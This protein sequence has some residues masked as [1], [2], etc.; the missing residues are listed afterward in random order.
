M[1]RWYFLLLLVI[2][3]AIAAFVVRTRVVPTLECGR[4]PPNIPN[5]LLKTVGQDVYETTLSGRVLIANLNQPVAGAAVRLRI[6]EDDVLACPNYKVVR[7]FNLVS[8]AQGN[9]RLPEPILVGLRPELEY[10][11]GVH[12]E[13][14]IVAVESPDCEIIPAQ[15]RTYA[16]ADFG[17]AGRAFENIR[18]HVACE[19]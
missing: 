17:Y 4:E 8:D 7:D 9:F 10:M 5:E 12:V 16:A 3:L 11:R 15:Q 1:R 18:V 6:T 2:A 13:L 14:A 19:P